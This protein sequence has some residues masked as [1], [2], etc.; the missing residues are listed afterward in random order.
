MGGILMTGVNLLAPE[1]GVVRACSV[2]RS[3]A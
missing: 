2:T 1:V 3:D